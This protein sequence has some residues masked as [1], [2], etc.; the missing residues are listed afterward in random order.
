MKILEEVRTINVIILFFLAAFCYAQDQSYQECKN[1]DQWVNKLLSHQEKVTAVSANYTEFKKLEGFKE[2]QQSEGKFYFEPVNSIRLEQ[3]TPQ[4]L[5]FISSGN[6]DRLRIDHKEITK[7]AN[8]IVFK[9]VKKII[10][11][12]FNGELI[13]KEKFFKPSYFLSDTE[14]I[15]KLTPE[16]RKVRMYITEIV[17]KFDQQSMIITEMQTTEKA[18]NTNVMKFYDVQENIELDNDLFTNF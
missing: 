11:G 12:M 4:D 13:K 5:I 1:P 7:E 15:I 17:L 8:L 2:P 14:F 18:G 16:D 9:Q 10:A 6:S 3:I